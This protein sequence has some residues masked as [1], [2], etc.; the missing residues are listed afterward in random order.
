MAKL[1]VLVHAPVLGPASWAPVA[2]EL[3]AA[4]HRVAIPALTG[5]ADA[6]PPYAPRLLERARAQMPASG[7]DRVVLVVHSGAGVFA[8]HLAET[9]M[10]GDVAVV[11]ADADLPPLSGAATVTH[12][13]YLPLL[14][15]MASDGLVPPWPRWWPDDVMSSLVPD[16]EARRS[17]AAE[18]SPLP[19]AFFEEELPPVPQAWRSRHPGY[20]R[21]SETYQEQADDAARRGWPVRE[22]PG[23]HLHMV[24]E[25][26]GVAAAITALVTD[27]LA[28]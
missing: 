27:G 10:A 3:A 19:L 5:F 15:D 28:G 12:R 13:A 2:E 6:G 11:F 4:G 7:D 1:F 14:Q 18:A 17:V 20:L 24:V 26:A 22:L 21:F 16:E 25:P 9:V 8:P 23:E